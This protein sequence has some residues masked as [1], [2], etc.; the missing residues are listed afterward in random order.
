VRRLIR[1]VGD[2]REDL[3]SDLHAADP[4]RVL[5]QMAIELRASEL[6]LYIG[7]IGN[8]CRRVSGV[9]LGM[10]PSGKQKKSTNTIMK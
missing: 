1:L 4:Q 3:T 2:L 7:T 10:S 5:R 8:K 9:I 6:E